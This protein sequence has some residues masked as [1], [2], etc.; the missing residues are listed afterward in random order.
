MPFI[1]HQASTSA[2]ISKKK[3]LSRPLYLFPFMPKQKNKLL[4]DQKRLENGDVL[5]INDNKQ[6]LE[7]CYYRNNSNIGSF[8]IE[9]SNQDTEKSTKD[10][11]QKLIYDLKK[12]DTMLNNPSFQQRLKQSDIVLPDDFIKKMLD[13]KV[14]MLLGRVLDSFKVENNQILYDPFKVSVFK[15]NDGQDKITLATSDVTLFHELLHAYH[16]NKNSSQFFARLS[17]EPVFKNYTNIEEQFTIHICNAYNKELGYPLRTA[18]QDN[19]NYVIPQNIENIE[20]DSGLMTYL[21]KD[22]SDLK[23]NPAFINTR[24]YIFRGK[25]FKP[26]SASKTYDAMF[27]NFKIEKWIIMFFIK[28]FLRKF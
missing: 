6:Q 10:Y 9:L 20:N 11:L 21:E 15:Q 4:T 27:S 28:K 16:Y 2:A 22:L 1:H 14:S 18:H 23:D 13:Y 19:A 17:I 26:Y 25:D 12:V 8:N 5:K 24:Q 3:P 7:V